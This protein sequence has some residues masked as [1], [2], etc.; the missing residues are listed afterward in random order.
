[1]DKTWRHPPSVCRQVS[2]V[3]GVDTL[4]NC[5]V[6][7]L[8]NITGRHPPSGFRQ[9]STLPW[10]DTLLNCRVHQLANMT[11]SW[12][13]HGGVHL[14]AVGSEHIAMSGHPSQ[15][16]GP[17][18]GQHD[19]LMNKTWRCSPSGCR[20]VITLPWVDTLLYC[21]VHQLAN[22]TVSWIKHGGV[23]LLAVGR[24]VQCVEWT[25]FSIVHQLT[26]MAN[27]WIKHGGVKV[28]PQNVL[29]QNLM[30]TKHPSTYFFYNTSNLQIP[31]NIL[32]LYKT[33]SLQKILF[34]NVLLQNVL[35]SK[36]NRSFFILIN[37]FNKM[38]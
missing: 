3:R 1:M 25:S 21:R 26:N 14:L 35:T 12:I 29:L 17:S 2:T 6:H 11:V 7:E 15:L 31:I 38:C 20:Q 30:F 10:V 4:I 24:W 27:S 19:C 13:K 18:A 36:Y 33:S 8:A 9:V 32:S 22:M 5:R 28:N 23:H 16:S 37:L 34:Q